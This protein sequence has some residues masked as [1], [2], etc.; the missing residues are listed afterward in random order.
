MYNKSVLIISSEFPP[1][2]GGI[3]KHAFDLARA[4]VSKKYTVTVFASQDFSTSEE[5]FEFNK[6]IQNQISFNQLERK[7]AL[8]YF[9][10]WRLINNFLK[11]CLPDRIIVTGRFSL[12]MGALIKLKYGKS[13]NIHAFVH[14]SE[15]S[16]KNKLFYFLTVNSLKHIENIWAVS[17]YTKKVIQNHVT[18]KNISILPNG[19]WPDDWGKESTVNEKVELIGDP[20]L[21]TVGQ[22]SLRKGQVRVV[23]ALPELLKFYPNIQYH[24]V[25][26]PTIKNELLKLSRANNSN[27]HLTIHGRISATSMLEQFYNNSQIFIMLSENQP[28]GDTEGFGIAILEANYFGKPAI[29]AKDCGIED[30]IK[31]GNNGRLVDGNNIAEIT[32]ALRDI[33]NNYAAYSIRAKNW[34]NQH[35]WSVLINKFDQ[36]ENTIV[37]V[38]TNF[39]K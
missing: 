31:D 16:N 26:L 19:L 17:S 36:I 3:G 2:P 22:L 12:W 18:K 9:N 15:L 23:K 33:M 10:R 29:G 28:D 27:N 14:G 30:A 35:H 7:G 24:V 4:L 11:K 5:N 37:E 39:P 34:A 1:G 38:P 25:G 32:E 8:T 6:Q 21:L 13:A 20:K